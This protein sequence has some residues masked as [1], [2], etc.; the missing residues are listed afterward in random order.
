MDGNLL[1]FVLVHVFFSKR[2]S[3]SLCIEK[4]HTAFFI[5]NKQQSLSRVYIIESVA[6]T[7]HL[8]TRQ[9]VKQTAIMASTLINKSNA[10]PANHR[11]RDG[12]GYPSPVYPPGK[13]PLNVWV[14]DKKNTHGYTN[15]KNLYPSGR[16]GM[17][18][19]S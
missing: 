7:Q 16:A 8:E 5:K 17:G 9:W 12:N 13:Y 3:L 18:M 10:A 19:G 11:G 1:H 4:M 14:W 6:T 15:G 2:G